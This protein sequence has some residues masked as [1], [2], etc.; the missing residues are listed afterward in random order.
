MILQKHGRLICDITK[1]VLTLIRRRH[2]NR[3]RRA[4]RAFAIQA[5]F[6]RRQI[7]KQKMVPNT[8]CSCGCQNN[9]SKTFS[10]SVMSLSFFFLAMSSG[11][12]TL[13]LDLLLSR[14]STF[15]TRAHQQPPF[16]ILDRDQPSLY[17]SFSFPF[18]VHSHNRFHRF[19]FF[20]SRHNGPNRLSLFPVVFYPPSTLR[21]Y[22]T[23]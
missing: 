11:Q 21:Q 22:R 3:D 15:P 20:S 13:V 16:I 23:S 10:R 7:S 18:N 4:Q 19:L 9:V 8:F 12:A 5:H 2:G 1:S 17:W 14:S 6:R